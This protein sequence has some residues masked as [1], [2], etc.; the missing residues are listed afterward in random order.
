MLLAVIIPLDEYRKEYEKRCKKPEKE[1]LD[2]LDII[3][4]EA[5]INPILRTKCVQDYDAKDFSYLRKLLLRKYKRSEEEYEKLVKLI[6]DVK[7]GRFRDRYG[8]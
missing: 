3:E 5:A 4:R 6:M 2:I 7:T 1:K 8:N